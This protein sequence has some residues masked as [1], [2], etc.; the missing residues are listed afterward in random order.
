MIH[1]LAASAGDAGWQDVFSFQVP[2][3]EKVVRTVL[4]YLGIA[5]IIRL[6]GKRQMS[7]LSTFDLIVALLLSNVVQNAVI[8]AD[9]SLV[10]GLLG[11]VVLVAFNA[12]LDRLPDLGPRMQWLV[13]GDPT[14]LVRD[15][16]LDRAALRHVALRER[17][18]LHALRHQG[19]NAPQEV[20]LASLDPG[21]T[22]TVELKPE[23][24]SATIGDLTKAVAELQAHLDRRLDE[25]AR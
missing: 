7:Q 15:G 25:L 10:G 12:L 16:A 19:A 1:A 23:Y 5:V 3:A 11:A 14:V 13:E 4:V 18:L 24:Q 21:G 22:L 17:L 2:P 6:A 20:K 9:N 8:G